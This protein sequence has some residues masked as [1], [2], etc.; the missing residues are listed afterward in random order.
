MAGEL[1]F[2]GRVRVFIV[3]RF[4]EASTVGLLVPSLLGTAALI[5]APSPTSSVGSSPRSPP[6]HPAP[7]RSSDK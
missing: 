5:G 4:D 3:Y 7:R 6:R 1:V 2:R